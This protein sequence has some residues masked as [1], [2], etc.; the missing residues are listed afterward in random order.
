ML[1]TILE[2]SHCE[3]FNVTKWKSL[4]LESFSMPDQLHSGTGWQTVA[5][6]FSLQQETYPIMSRILEGDSKKPLTTESSLRWMLLNDRP[7]C[8]DL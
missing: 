5:L 3:R 6:L 4:P 7:W 2:N 1:Q 8:Y